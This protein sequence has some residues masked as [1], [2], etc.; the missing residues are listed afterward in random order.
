MLPIAPEGRPYLAALAVLVALAHLF[1]GPWALPTWGLLLGALFLFRNLPREIPPRPLAVVSPV[2]AVVEQVGDG[3]DPF[4]DRDALCIALRQGPGGEFNLHSPVEGRV[5]R[6]WRSSA[7]ER[8]RPDARFGLWLATDERDDVVLAV[9]CRPWPHL[10]RCPVTTGDRLG[11]GRRCGFL[12]FGRRVE[13]YLPAT[14]RAEVSRGQRVR[15]GSDTIATLVHK[16]PGG[17]S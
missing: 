17:P 11:Q 16:Q 4:L 8:L 6:Y 13:L 2:D 12:G 9:N 15:A 3:R 1:M 10:T 14:A 5:Q 7:H